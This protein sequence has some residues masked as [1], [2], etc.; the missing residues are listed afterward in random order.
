LSLAAPISAIFS[1]G[2]TIKV[3]N[4]I[5]PPPF[6]FDIDKGAK[7]PGEHSSKT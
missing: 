7:H 6:I 4:F 2:S 1:V 3:I 5:F